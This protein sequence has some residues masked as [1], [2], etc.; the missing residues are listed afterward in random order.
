MRNPMWFVKKNL[1]K[2]K[3]GARA[4]ER[5]IARSAR[6]VDQALSD[7]GI[8]ETF[9]AEIRRYLVRC[10]ALIVIDLG[11]VSLVRRIMPARPPAKVYPLHAPQPVA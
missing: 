9:R 2:V 6:T 3:I 5:E 4:L 7:F 1:Q 10:L 11:L 8:D